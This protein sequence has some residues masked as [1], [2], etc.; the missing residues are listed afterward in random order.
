[1]SILNIVDLN[2]NQTISGVKTFA[3]GVDLSNI[4]TLILSGV[5]ISLTNRPTVNGTGVLLSG[6]AS[7]GTVTLPTTIVY[8]T[9]TQT[10][11]GSKIFNSFRIEPSGRVFTIGTGLNINSESGIVRIN[12]NVSS[13]FGGGFTYALTTGMDPNRPLDIEGR[14]RLV[15]GLS[16]DAGSNNFTS[17]S[18]HFHLFFSAGP[19]NPGSFNGAYSTTTSANYKSYQ[20]SPTTRPNGNDNQRDLIHLTTLEA[21]GANDEA[22]P[23]SSLTELYLTTTGT[24]VTTPPGTGL[25]ELAYAVNNQPTSQ[26]LH[27]TGDTVYLRIFPG[28]AGLVANTYNGIVTRRVTGFDPAYGSTNVYKVGVALGALDFNNNFNPSQKGTSTQIDAWALSRNTTSSAFTGIKRIERNTSQ[29]F[30]QFN[31]FY[32][33]PI[34]GYTGE[35]V[36]VDVF[37]RSSGTF[38]ASGINLTQGRYDGYVSKVLS[39]TGLE[40][41]LSIMNYGSLGGVGRPGSFQNPALTT[42]VG[43]ISSEDL[44]TGMQIFRGASDSVHRQYWAHNVFAGFRNLDATDLNVPAGVITRVSVGGLNRVESGS[45]SALGFNNKAYGFN[46]HAYGAHQENYNRD[47]VRIGATTGSYINIV[48]GR[49]GINLQ[50][51]NESL[52]ISGSNLKVE[53]GTGIFSNDMIISGSP[54]FGL[55]SIVIGSAS[56][57]LGGSG[58]YVTGNFLTIGGGGLNVITGTQSFIGGGR[59]NNISGINSIIGGGLANRITG[60]QSTIAGGVRN[61]ACASAFIG[62]GVNNSALGIYSNA[63]GGRCNS[64][65][66]NCSTVVG[67]YRNSA[68][69]CASIVAGGFC[70]TTSG[71]FSAIVGGCCNCAWGN[72]SF[73]GGGQ[74]N[75]TIDKNTSIGGGYFNLASGAYS[76]VAGGTFN[77]VIASASVVGGGSSNTVY[78]TCSSIVGGF[79]NVVNGNDS[80][81]GG[82]YRNTVF[83]GRSV[84]GGGT[85]NTG[86]FT[87]SAIVGGEGNFVSG[88]NSFIGGG[89]INRAT[90]DQAVIGGGLNNFATA[91]S[92]IV[93]GGQANC[94]RDAFTAI[95]GGILN[96]ASGQSA[97]VVG[98]T[99]NRVFANYS[100]IT[101]GVCNTINKEAIN[102]FIGGGYCNTIKNVYSVIGGGYKNC[103]SAGYANVAGGIYNCATGESSVVAGGKFNRA[104]ACESFIGGGSYNAACGP[105]NSIVVGG[106][107][108]VAN[109]P[110]SIIVGG[111]GNIND[112]S[113]AFIGGGSLN[114]I[115]L[116]CYEVIVGG[117]QNRVSGNFNFLGGGQCNNTSS[118]LSVIGGGFRNSIL[119]GT[120]S[121]SLIVGG[122]FNTV[123]GEFSLIGGGYRNSISGSCYAS[124]NGGYKNST[125]A[126][127][128]NNVAQTIGGGVS[129]LVNN[130]YSTIGGG[131]AN[132]VNSCTS[133]IVGGSANL[134]TTNGAASF[135]GGGCCNS[136]N[137]SCT[138]INGGICNRISSNFSTIGGGRINIITGGAINSCQSTIGGG[139]FNCIS[140]GL[141]TTIAGGQCNSI[142]GNATASVIGGGWLNS[143]GNSLYTTIAGGFCNI[144][145]SSSTASVIA[146]GAN[147]IIS[148]CRVSIIGGICNSVYADYASILGGFKNTIVTGHTG[149]VILGDSEDRFKYSFSPSSLTIDFS[150]G[151]YFADKKVFG[152]VPEL[153]TVTSNFA[154]SGL[155]N[156]EMILANSASNITGVIASGN[157]TGFNTSI[158]Q[159][160]AGQIQITGSG[161]GI[162]IGSYNNQYRTAGQFATISLLHTGSNGY[163]MYGNTI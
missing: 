25:V 131:V 83:G 112:S 74:Y 82:G 5:D 140:G 3:Q 161:I 99:S 80:F 31:V 118:R 128:T 134:I 19:A 114:L 70:N 88:R 39:N 69:G 51:P 60:F 96:I 113:A 125:S 58:N 84:I 104:N 36:V 54:I 30:D 92:S 81:L 124:I 149:A 11:T 85:S 154:I 66:G 57:I 98:G 41:T 152:A 100:N 13:S 26:Y 150:S 137:T 163:I 1:M 71:I 160:G 34:T 7:A 91:T 141:S 75:C 111:L 32:T 28:V 53:N 22:F 15:H 61:L 65:T 117:A 132:A 158:I 144:I 102:S 122:V 90:A 48:S 89:C 33:T 151:V 42:G 73:I 139:C 55:Q 40:I 135:I 126:S 116:G 27:A 115:E 157:V 148:G 101:N 43:I 68:R 37:N 2:N 94:A 162:R 14:G 120:T 129:N 105:N 67:G 6:E 46:S 38:I 87:G 127:T 108:N 72:V 8:T 23:T 59:L 17:A 79:I 64:A 95:L 123:S 110:H 35:S 159:I 63:V 136:I 156:G 16:L 103:T 138:T 76:N 86:Y 145:G 49:V 119:S 130:S 9:G 62:G 50:Y 133:S 107:A 143:I 142:I 24:V 97:T 12:T 29:F 52:H 106:N 147:N 109:Q 77:A 155:F 93:V 45:T 10:I 47:S 21:K 4:D 78:G 44:V 56:S 18:D 153:N 146:G 20:F 121:G